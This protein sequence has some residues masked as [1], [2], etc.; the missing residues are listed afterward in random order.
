MK[1]SR[2]MKIPFNY[3]DFDAIRDWVHDVFTKAAEL[4]ARVELVSNWDNPVESAVLYYESEETTAETRAR[5]K[6]AEAKI[7]AKR[8]RLLSIGEEA[9]RLRK[10]LGELE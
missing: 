3:R 1:R 9:E 7:A 5:L 4:N 10:E 2:T 6:Q 8:M